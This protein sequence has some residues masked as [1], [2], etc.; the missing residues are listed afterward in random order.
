M[1]TPPKFNIAPENRESQKETHL[2]TIHFQG[3]AVKLPGDIYNHLSKETHG[4]T[5]LAAAP[6]ITR[7][8][9]GHDGT[10]LTNPAVKHLAFL[11]KGFSMIFRNINIKTMVGSIQSPQKAIYYISGI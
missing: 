5:S 3:R 8:V 1:F 11:R 4:L 6:F 9:G 7:Y 2:P 10:A